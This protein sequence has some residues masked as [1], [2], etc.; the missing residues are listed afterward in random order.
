MLL[1][2]TP[3]FIRRMSTSVAWG[4]YD[5][6]E[7][8]VYLTFDDGPIPEITPWVLDQ[9]KKYHA[10]ATF[11]C[12]GRHVEA[13][14]EI[15]A[16]I[17]AEGHS[18]GNHTYDHPDGWKS[19][20]LTY[21]KSVIACSDMVKSSLFRPPYGRITPRQIRA[22]KSRYKIILWS[23][24]SQDY[25]NTKTPEQCVRNVTAKVRNGDIIVFHD[26]HKAWPNLS[27]ALPATLA[28]LKQAG[29]RF[30]AL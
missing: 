8:V 25:D 16:Q 18:V 26:S 19:G 15:Y 23:I 5:Q 7:R 29:F 1:I 2:R 11:F 4:D 9:L 27:E 6:P 14:P 22:L 10:K 12:L 21:Y 17:L 20:N 24:L 3:D 28:H 30:L 13:H